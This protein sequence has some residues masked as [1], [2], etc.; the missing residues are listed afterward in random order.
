MN[1]KI[2]ELKP[3]RLGEAGLEKVSLVEGIA[4]SL[5]LGTEL[6]GAAKQGRAARA[7]R[8]RGA[9]HVPVVS[10]GFLRPLSEWTGEA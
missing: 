4:G 9:G 6:P 8:A 5:L 10:H 1:M 2:S 7:R 3:G